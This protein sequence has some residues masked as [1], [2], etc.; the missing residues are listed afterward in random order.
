MKGQAHVHCSLNQSLVVFNNAAVNDL[1][2][3]YANPVP[4]VLVSS[5]TRAC[6]RKDIGTYNPA[7]LLCE[8]E[9]ITSDWF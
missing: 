9:D 7:C 5:S 8:I 1:Q 4:E 2:Q 6:I 3:F